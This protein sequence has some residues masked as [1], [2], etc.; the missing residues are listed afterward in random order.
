VGVM[1]KFPERDLDWPRIA[2]W[3]V[4]GAVLLV[5]T[6]AT[7]LGESGDTGDAIIL[8]LTVAVF[9][10]LKSQADDEY[11]RKIER[12]ALRD[13][14]ARQEA[15]ITEKQ[16]QEL[17][18]LSWRYAVLIGVTDHQGIISAEQ[19]EAD[20]KRW[21]H[22]IHKNDDG[23]PIFDEGEA[24]N[25]MAELSGLPADD[26]FEVLDVEWAVPG[27]PPASQGGAL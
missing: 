20:R 4:A 14:C 21:P 12:A 5:C 3:A 1:I 27:E 11:K 2:R 26:C 22:L 24:A 25:F 7:P 13:C 19:V 9:W 6:L 17:I 18:D 8:L 10:F 15:N 23:L 16:R